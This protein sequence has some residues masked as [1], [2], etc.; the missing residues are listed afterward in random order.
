MKRREFLKTTGA[1]SSISL[2]GLSGCLAEAQSG[3]SG[4]ILP[5]EI[6]DSLN[7]A[8][9]IGD[10][11]SINKGQISVTEVGSSDSF[12]Y[13]LNAVGKL[14]APDGGLFRFFKI[15]FENSD[16]EA[17]EAPSFTTSL[18]RYKNFG[19]NVDYMMGGYP[20]EIAVFT[21]GEPAIIPDS[22]PSAHNVPS[23]SYSFGNSS[24]VGYPDDWFNR[25]TVPPNST[26][27]GWVW[28]L[29]Y[30]T[31]SVDCRV[32]Y[33]RDVYTWE[34]STN[35]LDKSPQGTDDVSI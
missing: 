33:Q 9:S 28:G 1:V 23:I 12:N 6:G 10:S 14:V 2:I 15:R 8:H 35:E 30:E 4:D 19:E 7:G 17:K 3:L 24:I 18:G 5:D 32:S 31:G 16:I 29:T 34:A 21:D 26:L 20:T 25:P 27:E 22:Y 13:N 11:V